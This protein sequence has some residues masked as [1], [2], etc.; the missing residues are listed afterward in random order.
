M[1]IIKSFNLG[2]MLWKSFKWNLCQ[3][4]LAT[5]RADFDFR[6][7]SSK[8]EKFL[9]LVLCFRRNLLRQDEQHFRS[10]WRGHTTV[11]INRTWIMKHRQKVR[12]MKIHSSYDSLAWVW[13]FWTTLTSRIA[14]LESK[15]GQFTKKARHWGGAI[16]PK[17]CKIQPH[18]ISNSALCTKGLS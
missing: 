16:Y 11:Q 5:F 13:T 12:L 8:S 18:W 3:V 4:F 9:G 15:R 1:S 6:I 14:K 7:L 17:R 2:L 10:E